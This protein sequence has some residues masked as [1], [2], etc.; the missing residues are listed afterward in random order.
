MTSIHYFKQFSRST[1][2][3]SWLRFFTTL[4]ILNS[5]GF[6]LL[7]FLKWYIPIIITE[8]ITLLW[9]RARFNRITKMKELESFQIPDYIWTAFRKRHPNISV[10][11]Y[12]HIEDGFKD[13]L[14][15]HIWIKQAYAMPSHS[16]DA[17][18]H[19]LIEEYDSYYRVMCETFLGYHLIHKPHDQAPTDSQK[20]SQRQQ[21]A[22][23]WQAAC[24]IHGLDP[25]KTHI[26]PRI[27][28]VDAHIRWEQGLI[29]SLPFLIALYTQMSATSAIPNDQAMSSCSSNSTTACSSMTTSCTSS[30]S[31]HDS[32]H[33]SNSSDSSSS[34]SSCSSCG[35]GGGD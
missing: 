10:T 9:L 2:T 31:S 4:I 33:S 6:G 32:N 34:C 5:I 15:L 13:Y 18:W 3:A 14:A 23:T 7:Y 16:V 19:L 1:Y 28:Q 12:K 24:H 21:L 30:G 20:I 25:Q 11:S 29:F 17:L 35:G 27:F 8:V 26:L 22:N